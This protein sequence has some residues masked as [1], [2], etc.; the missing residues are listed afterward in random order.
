LNTI[1]PTYINSRDVPKRFYFKIV[2]DTPKNDSDKIRR[3]RKGALE[4]KILNRNDDIFNDCH[5]AEI[6]TNEDSIWNQT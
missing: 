4:D 2:I 1:S 6:P 3:K 5:E